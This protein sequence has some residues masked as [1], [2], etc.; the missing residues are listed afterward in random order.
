MALTPPGAQKR[1]ALAEINVTPMV[2]VVL[3]LLVIFM[4]TAPSIKQIEG[5]EVN[6][7]KLEH[8]SAENIL[9]ED[10]RT[11]AITA[12]GLIIRPGSKQAG[13]HY[14]ST[15]AL[16]QDLKQ[17]KDECEKAQKQPVVVIAGDRD[18][19]Y[20]RIV[21]VWNA[22]KLAGIRQVCFQVE[23]IKGGAQQ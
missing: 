8:S 7:P 23:G 21:Q 22:V 13:D 11:L 19:R 4:I 18:L 12:D 2:D 10:A 9:T 6:L 16:I 15:A 1:H 14:E 3:V 5:I 20:Q 17:Y